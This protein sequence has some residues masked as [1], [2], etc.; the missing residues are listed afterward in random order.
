MNLSGFT[1]VR[2]GRDT[3]ACGESKGGV[4]KYTLTFRWCDPSDVF[5]RENL[6]LQSVSLRVYYLPPEFSHM[7]ANCVYIPP[8]S[9]R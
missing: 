1:A 8:G 2:A 4:S 3:K 5:V 7:T 9:P 6:E